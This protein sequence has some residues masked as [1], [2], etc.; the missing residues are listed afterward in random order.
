SCAHVPLTTS[1]TVMANGM[2]IE[3]RKLRGEWSNGMLCSS[4]EL[5]LGDDHAGIRIL[6]PDLTA[7]TP[8]TD[9]LGLEPDVL[10]ELEVNPNR[11]DAMS[12]AGLA[13]D[14][15]ARL[16]VGFRLTEPAVAVSGPPASDAATVEIADPDLCGR[17]V[18]RVL[19][20]VTVG[21]SPEW[22]QQRL[23]L[24]GMRPINALV[25]ISNYVMLELGQPNHPYDLAKV[26]GGGLR[27]RGAAD[28]D[29]LVT[30]DGVERVLAEDDLLI[31]AADDT[32]VGIAG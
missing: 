18:V 27:V 8:I 30:L 31:C 21:E 20:G 28:G 7:G 29:R 6:D 14:V 9:A 13:R 22:M 3:R 24:L 5:E 1:G 17:F 23:T 4:R 25:D 10:W 11:P 15:A 16:G 19:R 26:P 2:K 12:V 32:P